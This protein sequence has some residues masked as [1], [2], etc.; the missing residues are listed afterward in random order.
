MIARHRSDPHKVVN[1]LLSALCHGHHQLCKETQVVSQSKHLKDYSM[2]PCVC[3]VFMRKCGRN[4]QHWKTFN[5]KANSNIFGELW[6]CKSG[7][8]HFIP[9]KVSFSNAESRA[10]LPKIAKSEQVWAF[11]NGTFCVMK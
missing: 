6:E 11:K 3:D 7:I 2:L 8:G 5:S 1:L 10:L 4:P 9:P